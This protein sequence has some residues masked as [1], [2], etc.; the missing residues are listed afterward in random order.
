MSSRGSTRRT[1]PKTRGLREDSE[2]LVR[3]Q[4]EPYLPLLK[5]P[6]RLIPFLKELTSTP[7][8]PVLDLRSCVL[9]FSVEP[10]TQLK[11][12]LGMQKWTNLTSMKLFLLVVPQEF[13]RFRNSFRTFS[14]ERNSTSQST[15]MKLLLM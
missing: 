9:I 1:L 15:P 5:L 7:A 3:G 4:R 6:L 14:V 11:S 10:W 13:P 12:P 2:L 8:S